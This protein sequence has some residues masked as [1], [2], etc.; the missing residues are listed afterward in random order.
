MLFSIDEAQKHLRVNTLLG[1]APE[2]VREEVTDWLDLHRELSGFYEMAADDPVL[3]TLVQQ[4][5]GLRMVGLPNL[6]EALSW[7]IIGQ[8][9]NLAFA[10]S[11]KRR[12]VEQFGQAFG[13]TGETRY[14]FPRP[15]VIAAL[16]VEDFLPFQFSRRK[17]EYLI[18]VAQLFE[19][20]TL[21]YEGLRRLSFDESH[22]KLVSIRGIGNWTANYVL[23]KCFRHPEA[24]PIEDVGLHNAIKYMLQ[25]DRKPTMP[26]LQQMADRWGAWKAYATFYLWHSLVQD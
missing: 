7:S 10:Y 24:F 2:R 4:Y 26:E 6:F 3:F 19:A 13:Y 22:Q 20:G 23:M 16:Q 1:N 25:M 21:S 9:I 14:L 8:Q 12:M 15:A 5:R 18:G 11:L 17:A